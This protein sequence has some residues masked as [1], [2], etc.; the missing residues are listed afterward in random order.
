M[1]NWRQTGWRKGVRCSRWR[2]SYCRQYG[3]SQCTTF[4]PRQSWMCFAFCSLGGQ[5]AELSS[6]GTAL[7]FWPKN[8]NKT[9]K[10][11]V[12]HLC[13]TV[14]RNNLHLIRCCGVQR[15]ECT[16]T[17]S[18]CFFHWFCY[19]SSLSGWQLSTTATCQLSLHEICPR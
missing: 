2:L 3:A 18:G 13:C 9:F 10:L 5:G 1:R 6:P 7:M 14:S 19:R 12:L 15:K 16:H 8:K 17:E 11:H 4:R